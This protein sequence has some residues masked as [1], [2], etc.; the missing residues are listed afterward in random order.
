VLLKAFAIANGIMAEMIPQ[1]LKLIQ[2]TC[3]THRVC[4]KQYVNTSS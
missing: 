4:N 1:V 2:P 3:R